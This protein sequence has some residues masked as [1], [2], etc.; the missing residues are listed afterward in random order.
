MNKGRAE[1]TPLFFARVVGVGLLLMAALA[2]YANF[3]VIE[4]LIVEG[5]AVK[6]A[7]NITGNELVFRF[8][9]VGFVIVLVLDVIISWALYMLLK[10]IDSQLALLAAFFRLIYTAVFAAVIFNFLSVLQLLK[11][12]A[13]LMELGTNQLR[14]QVM[15]RID[16]FNNG[17]VIG[18]VFFGIHL[19]FVGYLV[20]KSGFMPKLLGVLVMLGGL[21]YLIDSFAKIILSNYADYASL[22]LLIVAIPGTIGEVGFA[23]W[24][25]VRG[26]KIPD[27]KPA[28]TN[29]AR[30]S[31]L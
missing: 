19:L 4:G 30:G 20:Y 22:F 5:D 12:E 21:G 14:M 18:L 31:S 15:M 13:Y 6:T 26:K 24:L 8:G 7:T 3:F 10:R 23:I 16:A 28:T 9:I 29:A 25:L 11:E 17:W 1:K 27:T 2:I